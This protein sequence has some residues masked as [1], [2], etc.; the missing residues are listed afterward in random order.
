M[1]DV[2]FIDN[3]MN[4]KAALGDAAEAFLHEAAGEVASQAARNSP[5]DNGQLKGSW[6]YRMD[7]SGREA[8]IGSPLENAVWNEFGTGEYALKG[9]GR[10]SAWYVPAEGYSGAKKPTYKGEVIIVYGRGGKQFYKTDG[11]K[12]NRSLWKA[13]QKLRRAIIKQA[14]KKFKERM[15]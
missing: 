12:P 3:S 7:G 15:K 8:A 2:K 5:V 13:F 4:V 11:K 10:K 14:E 9:D 1:P 6:A